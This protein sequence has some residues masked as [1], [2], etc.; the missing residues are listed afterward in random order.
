L[1]VGLEL[2]AMT[3]AYPTAAWLAALNMARGQRR[4]PP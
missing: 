1:R 2:P 4:P 3:M